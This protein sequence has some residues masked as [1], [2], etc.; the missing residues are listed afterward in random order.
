MQS[1]GE[2]REK[3][4]EVGPPSTTTWKFNVYPIWKKSL[5]TGK[6]NGMTSEGL[7]LWKPT[8][9]QQFPE[10]RGVMQYFLLTNC[11]QMPVCV[12]FFFHIKH[13]TEEHVMVLFEISKQLSHQV[14]HNSTVLCMKPLKERA[15]NLRMPLKCAVNSVGTGWMLRQNNNTCWLKVFN[16]HELLWAF[17][18][19]DSHTAVARMRRWY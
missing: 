1:N 5:H 12:F 13:Q 6:M 15:W 14:L 7:N 9:R 17:S 16:I 3:P 2:Q 8:H 19:T 11:T 10:I 18:F 4:E